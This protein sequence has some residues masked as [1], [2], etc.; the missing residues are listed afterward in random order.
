MP[1]PLTVI[2]GFLGAGKTSLLNAVLE[3]AQ[4]R[5]IAVLVNDFGAVS[6]DAA[7][8]STR[9]ARTI[10]LANGCICCT[11]V[12]GL[13]AALIEVL[14]LDPPPDHI[15]IEAS[16]VSDPCRIAQVARADPSLRDDGTLV[17]VAA[18]RIR[19][20]A[21]D[22]HVGDTVLRQ[23]AAADLVVLNKLDLVTDAHCNDL[24]TWLGERAPGARLVRA[25][26]ARLPNEIVLGPRPA[27][28]D[29][30]KPS[31]DW[32]H[33][34]NAHA[35]FV[36]RTLRCTRPLS[37]A[38]LRQALDALPDT[39]LRAKGYVRLGTTPDAWHVIQAVGRRWTLSPA[40]FTATESVLVMIAAA[41]AASL[42]DAGAIARVFA[43][44]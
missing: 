33:A 4:G 21:T 38:A 3:Q 14:R 30:G 19:A 5:R 34:P 10:S 35:A 36:S 42:D 13:A 9:S 23:L 39:V 43:N 8:V 11:L 6:V 29:H 1:I 40:A 28:V 16:G 18:D 26:N 25:V 7:L 31:R 41:G 17:L 24:V 37:E 27:A 15:L 32:V 12:D 22:R 20:L 2:G 44:A